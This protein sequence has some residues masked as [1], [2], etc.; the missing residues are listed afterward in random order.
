MKQTAAVIGA[1]PVGC[2]TALGLQQ[3]GYEVTVFER[4]SADKFAPTLNQLLGH[5]DAGLAGKGKQR[6]SSL[7]NSRSINLAISVRGLTALEFVDPRLSKMVLDNAVPMRARMIHQK[8]HAEAASSSDV[9]LDSQAYSSH[10]DCINSVSRLLLSRLLL[11]EVVKAGIEVCWEYGVESID[12]S[13]SNEGSE[14]VG[15]VFDVAGTSDKRDLS[16]NAIFGCDG[17]HSK[18]RLAIQKASVM[19]VAESNV[20]NHYVELHIPPLDQTLP[21]GDEKEI[22]NANG[23]YALDPNHLHIWPRHDFMLIAL[24]NQDGSFTSTFFGP[25]RVFDRH[26]QDSSNT[27]AFFRQQFPDALHVIG[28]EALVQQICNRRPSTLGSVR[29]DRYHLDGRAIILGDAAHAMVPFYGQGLNCGLEDVRMLLQHMD[30]VKNS[31]SPYNARRTAFAAYSKER[32]SDLEAIQELAMNNY[33]EMS[34][35]VVK[36]SFLLRKRLDNLLEQHLPAG[37]WSSLY[38]NVT[39]SNINYHR[40]RRIEARQTLI[41]QTLLSTTTVGAMAVAAIGVMRVAQWARA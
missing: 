6:E 1:G 19:K 11:D 5:Q 35:H 7:S 10:G 23:R 31:S 15:L 25:Q 21:Y 32:R 36:R 28:E 29:C 17:H 40:A 38:S 34:S 39:F 41:I 16:F 33:R 12:V 24:A 4:R 20:D 26:L 9:Q 18:V 27:I 30:K 22:V 13:D 2:L 8:P 3:R 14:D 37:W